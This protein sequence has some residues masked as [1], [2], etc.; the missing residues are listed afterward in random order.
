MDDNPDKQD[1]EEKPGRKPP[2]DFLDAYLDSDDAVADGSETTT[3]SDAQPDLVETEDSKD[4]TG[5]VFKNSVYDSVYN[6]DKG[7]LVVFFKDIDEYNASI[8]NEW[9]KPISTEVFS[10]FPLK[11]IESTLASLPYQLNLCNG[12]WHYNRTDGLFKID[13]KKGKVIVCR[14]P[15]IVSRKF[16]D[17]DTK[18]HKLQ[19]AFQVSG[20]EIQLVTCDRDRAFSKAFISQL[21]KR[22]AFIPRKNAQYLLEYLQDYEEAYLNQIDDWMTG[23]SLGWLEDGSFIPYRKNAVLDPILGFGKLSAAIA[24]EGSRESWFECISDA[25]KGSIPGRIAIATSLSSVLVRKLDKTGPF[26]HMWGDTSMGKTVALQVAASVWGNPRIGEYILTFKVTAAGLPRYNAVLRDIPLL[27]DELQLSQPDQ[28]DNHDELIYEMTEGVTKVKAQGSRGIAEVLS[29]SNCIISTGETPIVSKESG[30]GTYARTIEIPLDGNVFADNTSTREV[31]FS[32][33]GFAGREFVQKLQE[34]GNIDKARGIFNS[35][36][37]E[38]FIPGLNSKQC[39]SAALIMTADALAEEWL[40]HDGISLSV[41]DMMPYMVQN[42]DISSNRR[43]YVYMCE[44]VVRNKN[45]LS[46]TNG[47]A[48]VL[49]TLDVENQIAYIIRSVFDEAVKN[50]G[51]SSDAMLRWMKS[52]NLI[53][54]ELKGYMKRKWIGQTQVSCVALKLQGQLNGP[55][56]AS[57]DDEEDEQVAR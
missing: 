36:Y 45:R 39:L 40:F 14:H 35:K 34:P 47:Q 26:I 41:A 49:G 15:I 31:V 32:N 28:K 42:D 52:K 19:I 27:I 21:E 43:G 30:A 37:T 16:I 11:S 48:Q 6:K 29:W 55:E 17:K 5:A 23:Q 13:E 12:A 24:E 38:I 18:E 44:W 1:P 53:D 4:I 46:K 57:Q 10:P 56:V 22:G 25:R 54:T 9:I 33:Y 8:D 50:A 3:G 20:Y 51:F 7:S 2:R